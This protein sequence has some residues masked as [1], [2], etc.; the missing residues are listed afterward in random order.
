[1]TCSNWRVVLALFQSQVAVAWVTNMNRSGVFRNHR[2]ILLA[3]A[4]M[5]VGPVLGAQPAPATTAASTPAGQFASLAGTYKRDFLIGLAIDFNQDM[6]PVSREEQEIIK[7]HFN[8][9]TP[10]NSMKPQSVHPAEDRWTFET[11][12]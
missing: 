9:I 6:N 4:L 2:R 5:L 8:C 10:E 12:D 11:A 7:R 3:A 1:M